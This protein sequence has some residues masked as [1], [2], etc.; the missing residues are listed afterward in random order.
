MR[1]IITRF[2]HP[3]PRM[4]VAFVLL[5]SAQ[6][7]MAQARDWWTV[8]DRDTAQ[9]GRLDEIL[10]RKKVYLN[11]TF[12]DN[13]PD[14]QINTTERNDIIQTVKEAIAS[15]KDMKMVTYPEEA[16]FAVL[17]RASTGQGTGEQ[18][19]NFSLL[20]D[21]E[22]EVA[23]EV[24]VLVPG[25][26]RPDGTRM[27]RIVWDASSPNTQTEAASAARFTIDGF[28]WELKKLRAKK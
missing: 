4:L 6:A 1:S 10:T 5:V 9:R 3:V 2:R 19:P 17:V 7:L 25:T 21:A 15:Q 20:L 26:R 18:G 28:L 8:S 23:I 27:P 13:R 22:A 11:V 12:S 16:E 24:L 14:S